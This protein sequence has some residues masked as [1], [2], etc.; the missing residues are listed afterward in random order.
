MRPQLN[1]PVDVQLC[2]TML[3]YTHVEKTTPEINQL[4]NQL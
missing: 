4:V 2:N 1:I 3:K